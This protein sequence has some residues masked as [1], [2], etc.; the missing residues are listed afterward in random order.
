MMLDE[1][2]LAGTE[3]FDCEIV[4]SHFKKASDPIFY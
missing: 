2:T 3:T 1:I 4:V